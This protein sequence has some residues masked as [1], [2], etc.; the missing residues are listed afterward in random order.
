M[1]EADYS[2]SKAREI[3]EKLVENLPVSESSSEVDDT[4]LSRSSSENSCSSRLTPEQLEA[5][6]PDEDDHI[7]E[8]DCK[9]CSE[10]LE[11][12]E[13]HE[14]TKE[15]QVEEEHV[16]PQLKA[17]SSRSLTV[18][19]EQ[20]AN[21]HLSVYEEDGERKLYIHSDTPFTLPLTVFRSYIT[22]VA[23]DDIEEME[24]RRLA[25]FDDVSV[26]SFLVGAV[27]AS[28]FILWIYYLSIGLRGM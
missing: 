22:E 24:R 10:Q 14:H 4:K 8:E 6:K 11:E 15:E 19:N 17:S 23:G 13:I 28:A 5:L 12:G 26:A 3:A 16:I 27:L 25:E 2:L 21:L 7:S 20:E 1:S 18:T 9:V